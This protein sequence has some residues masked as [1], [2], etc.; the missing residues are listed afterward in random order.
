M[1]I[2][3]IGQLAAGGTCLDRM[4][5]LRRLGHEVTGFDV[6]PFQS[7]FRLIRSMQWRVKP[8]VLL[9]RLNASIRRTVDRGD[10]FDLLWIDK[11]V[12][13]FPETVEHARC[14]CGGRALHFTP[15]AQFLSNRSN[16]F[17][18]AVPLYD[19]LVTTKTF[20]VDLYRSA[21]AR[22]VILSQQSY[23]PVRYARPVARDEFRSGVGFIGHYEPE[24]GRHVS[25]IGVEVGVQVW[26]GGWHRASTRRRVPSEV[27]RGDGLWEADYVDALTSF[28]I[29]LGL[30]SKYIPEQH[31]TRTFEIPAAGTFLLAERTPEHEEF[32]EEGHE[33]EFFGSL[34]EMI[35][36][37]RFYLENE[38]LRRRIAERGRERCRRSGY[39]TDSVL[40]KVLESIE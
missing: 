20:E 27:V 19:H 13:I 36:K 35:S 23:C 28:K 30:L 5:S 22:N 12:W 40:S 26:G 37:A 4:R 15:D 10:R 33:A 8:R 39:D 29:G 38:V 25:A 24:Y 9:R 17:F 21:G 7:R 31:T 6:S 1:R 34:E 18:D 16:H 3:Y 32:F 2:L 11:G 14:R